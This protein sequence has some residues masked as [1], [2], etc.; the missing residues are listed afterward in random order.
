MQDAL[1]STPSLRPGFS[2]GL[3]AHQLAELRAM[4]AN[5]NADISAHRKAVI[6][7]YSLP[8]ARAPR[9]STRV[10]RD[11]RYGPHA[12]QIL[13]VC[14]TAGAQARPAVLFIHGGAFTHG[15]KSMNGDVDDSV[16]VAFVNYENRHLDNYG[17]EF[18]QCLTACRGKA[19][20]VIQCR[21]HNHTSIVAHC[22]SG[23]DDLGEAILARD[24]GIEACRP[25]AP[26]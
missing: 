13:D 20:R 1:N 14:E 8:V 12:R 21:S 16:P 18:A 3:T 17:L 4:G 23:D 9:D 11:R 15:N 10:V 26:R 6:D 19:P 7:L 5:G 2:A 24:C 25:M 22:N